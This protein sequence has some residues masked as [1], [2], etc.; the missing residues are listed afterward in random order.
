[1]SE[2]HE[3]EER[4]ATDDF[5]R[6]LCD[7]HHLWDGAGEAS[8]EAFWEWY[9]EYRDFTFEEGTKLSQFDVQSVLGFFDAD[10]CA[11]NY[12]DIKTKHADSVHEDSAKIEEHGIMNAT[13]RKQHPLVITKRG[14]DADN[15]SYRLEVKRLDTDGL[16]N[17]TAE[18]IVALVNFA[19]LW[20]PK[21]CLGLRKE[22]FDVKPLVFEFGAID[23]SPYVRQSGFEVFNIATIEAIVEFFNTVE[24]NEGDLELIAR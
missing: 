14:S 19:R 22:I 10:L 24:A 8:P 13:E 2:E 15:L 3:N 9:Q 1:M 7:K 4:I 18:K 17:A 21:S 23:K 6:K 11:F 5:L 16:D 12:G 20:K